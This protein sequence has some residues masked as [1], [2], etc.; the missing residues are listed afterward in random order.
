MRVYKFIN[1]EFGL[2]SIKSKT[3]KVSKFD[4]L[5]DPFELMAMSLEEKAQR[6]VLRKLIKDFSKN[7]GLISFCRHWHNPVVWTHYADNHKGVSLGFDVPARDLIDVKY[8]T[9]RLAIANISRSIDKDSQLIKTKF[10]HWSYEA[11]ARM[12]IPLSNCLKS[13]GK[14]GDKK[15]IYT[16][17]F[18]DGLR[19]REVILGHNYT[20]AEK[21]VLEANL[22]NSGV[23]ITQ[24]RLAFKSFSVVRQKD[25]NLWNNL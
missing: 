25:K 1:Q 11:E 10:S 12:L 9:H 24:A 19:L 16:T 21:K 15:V 7:T 5:N 3:I 13:N 8:S 2:L 17:N 20:T 6:I 14:N 4:E 18:G 22:A 23:E